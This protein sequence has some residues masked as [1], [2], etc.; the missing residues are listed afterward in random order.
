MGTGDPLPGSKAQPERDDHSP[1]SSAEV[2]N[3]WEL[4]LLSPQVPSWCVMGQ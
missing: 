4:Y 2:E 1:T 3:E